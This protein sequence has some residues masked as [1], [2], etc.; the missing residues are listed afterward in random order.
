[1]SQINRAYILLTDTNQIIELNDGYPISLTFSVADIKNFAVKSGSYSKEIKVYGSKENNLV[2]NGLFNINVVDSSFDINQKKRCIVYVNDVPQIR[3]YF[4]LLGVKKISPQTTEGEQYLVYDAIVF[5]EVVNFFDTVGDAKLEDIRFDNVE[6]QFVLD[7]PEIINAMTNHTW[8]NKY[9]YFLPANYTNTTYYVKDFR[10]AIYAKVYLDRIFQAAGFSYESDFITSEPF[11]RL[12]VPFNGDVASWDIAAT[13]T[14]P[15]ITPAPDDGTTIALNQFKPKNVLQKQF[16]IS[17][18][19]MFCWYIEKHPTI[20]K[21]LIIKTRNDYYANPNNEYIDW[22]HKVDYKKTIDIKYIPELVNKEILLTYKQDKTQLLV[23]YFDDNKEIYGAER[24]QF[25]NEYVTGEKR[26]ELI[27]SPSMLIQHF[28]SPLPTD[29]IVP[30]IPRENGQNIRI[31]YHGGMIAGNWSLKYV[32]NV[33][34]GYQTTGFTSYAYAGHYDNPVSPTFDINFGVVQDLAYNYTQAGLTDHTLYNDYWYNYISQIPDGRLMT[35]YFNL[36]PNDINNLNFAKKIWIKESFFILNKIVE[37]N[38]FANGLTKVELIKIPDGLTNYRITVPRSTRNLGGSFYGP[39]HY[40]DRIIGNNNHFD[41]PTTL[42]GDNNFV[43]GLGNVLGNNN[44]IT[45]ATTSYSVIGNNNSII[46]NSR[47][48]IV[49]DGNVI[50]SGIT[51]VTLLNINNYTA[52]T[53]NETVTENLNVTST[54][55]VG[56]HLITSATTFITDSGTATLGSGGMAGQI[57]VTNSRVGPTSIILV[58][59]QNGSPIGFP[60]I[61]NR[62]VGVDF[63]ISST[64]PTDTYDVGWVMI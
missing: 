32:T 17:L 2:F 57:T 24:I 21:R 18:M 51:G 60:F 55:N 4:R 39:G 5:D 10:P 14:V 15:P 48:M 30:D 50:T 61:S 22:T 53:N 41:G 38:P 28:N 47:S 44:I 29:P 35:A 46:G 19:N 9:T 59:P 27:F 58:T 52:T 11:T 6:D 45:G 1:M 12:V 40:H 23:D 8:E 13:P 33:N 16:F 34:L 31:L 56:G 42:L 37:Y 26:V 63:T 62:N 54:L 3:G 7:A 49:G 64:D 43:S 36:T 20:E 25:S